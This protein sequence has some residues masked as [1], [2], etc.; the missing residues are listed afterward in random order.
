MAKAI[1]RTDPIPETLQQFIA[2]TGTS[3]PLNIVKVALVAGTGT[4]GGDVLGWQNPEAVAILAAIVCDLTTAATGTP[5][6]DAG[7]A[8]NATTSSDTLMDGI[9][10]GDAVKVISSYSDGGSNGKAVRKVDA[11]GGTNDHITI[12]PSAS[13]AG[14][15]GSAYIIYVPVS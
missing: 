5:T 14:L 12:T 1:T 9:A 4:G 11:K 3:L 2:E 13:A 8:A 6:A 7:V 10:I 15:V